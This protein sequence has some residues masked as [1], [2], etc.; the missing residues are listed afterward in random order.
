M[1]SNIVFLGQ[2]SRFQIQFFQK[3][4]R[5]NIIIK[6]GLINSLGTDSRGFTDVN[7]NYTVAY[8]RVKKVQFVYRHSSISAVSISAV[9]DLPRFII[10]SYF[11]PL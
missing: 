9:F 6:I 1:D 7:C 5:L 10:L 4:L 8:E 2:M 3:Y 11:P